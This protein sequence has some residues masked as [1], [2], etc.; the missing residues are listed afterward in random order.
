MARK[1]VRVDL[2]MVE[3]TMMLMLELALRGPYEEGLML[4]IANA[5]GFL[6][7]AK[8]I[9]RRRVMRAKFQKPT[10]AADVGP[11]SPRTKPQKPGGRRRRKDRR[12]R[13]GSA[14]I[15]RSNSAAAETAEVA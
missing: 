11:E 10:R 1:N 5:G 3:T 13:P 15:G 14:T 2:N 12:I 8:E 9:K 6:E 7:V 4:R